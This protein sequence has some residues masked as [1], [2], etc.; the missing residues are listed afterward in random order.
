MPTNCAVVHAGDER[1]R[2]NRHRFPLMKLAGEL[3]V[4]RGLR[5]QTTFASVTAHGSATFC[6]AYCKLRD[7]AFS[8]SLAD[9]H[10]V[11]F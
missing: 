9:I 2:P 5:R 10:I 7:A 11:R 1:L 8:K 4:G 6:R 3:L